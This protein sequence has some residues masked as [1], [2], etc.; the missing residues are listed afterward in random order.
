MKTDSGF[1]G[2][3]P[4]MQY[5]FASLVQWG[6]HLAIDHPA[7]DAQHQ[8]IFKLVGE[9]HALW[10]HG[11]GVGELCGIVDKLSRVLESHFHYEERLLAE[12]GYPDLA[13][14]AAEHHEMLEDLASIRQHLER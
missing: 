9:I 5:S 14:H 8:A 10:R 6:D 3:V 1:F 12:I 7:I 4:M 2:R 11:A 13:K